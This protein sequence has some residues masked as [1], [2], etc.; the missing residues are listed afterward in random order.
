MR[1]LSNKNK[2]TYIMKDS[3][4]SSEDSSDSEEDYETESG[5]CKFLDSQIDIPKSVT[6]CIRDTFIRKNIDSY[7]KELKTKSESIE[8][9]I[10]N[11]Y[12]AFSE[13]GP[14]ASS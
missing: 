7:A 5:D 6:L 13:L 4:D 2:K 1:F 11:G 8:M 12:K 9:A 3:S 14:I 10:L